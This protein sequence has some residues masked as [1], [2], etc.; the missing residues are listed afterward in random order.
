MYESGDEMEKYLAKLKSPSWKFP[1]HFSELAKHLFYKLAK[2]NPLERYTAKEALGHP[3]ITRR[4]G[5]IPLSFTESMSCEH[6]KVK[7]VNV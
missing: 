2:V 3:W 7:L 4:P 6:S 5:Q 1:P